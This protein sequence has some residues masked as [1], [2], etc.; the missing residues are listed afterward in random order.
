MVNNCTM[1]IFE[2][3]P[4]LINRHVSCIIYD[5]P[6][7]D[8]KIILYNK[9]YYILQNT[10]AGD[11]VPIRLLENYKYSWCLKKGNRTDLSII[12]INIKKIFLKYPHIHELWQ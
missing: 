8:G 1:E 4:D 5:K 10:I 11:K 6:C 12:S 9:E 3:T 7:A 2:I